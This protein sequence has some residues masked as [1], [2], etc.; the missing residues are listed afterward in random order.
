MQNRMSNMELLRILAMFFIVISHVAHH[1]GLP[2]FDI[3]H[4]LTFNYIISQMFILLGRIGTV[5]FVMLTGFFAVKSGFKISSLSKLWLL[6]F[7]YSNVLFF[8]FVFSGS[9]IINIRNII[10]TI[11]PISFNQYWFVSCYFFLYLL[12][13]LIN[14]CINNLNKK[15]HFAVCLIW[16]L[17]W[18]VI[19]SFILYPGYVTGVHWSILGW[20]VA[21]YFIGSYIRLYVD[22]SYVAKKVNKIRL[23]VLLSFGLMFLYLMCLNL[24]ARSEIHLDMWN[25][26]DRNNIFVIISAVLLFLIFVGKS[27]KSIIWINRISV[28]MIGVYMVHCNRLTLPWLMQHVF[29][30]SKYFESPYFVLRVLYVSILVF[31]GSLAVEYIRRL[32]FRKCS[33]NFTACM[34]RHDIAIQ[35]FF[36]QQ[37]FI[38]K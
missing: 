1:S 18:S 35:E 8:I 16:L 21:L 13:P 24:L 26:L 34:K 30:T 14:I 19:P 17:V 12:S 33:E 2:V 7:F 6:T 20:F 4:E 11:L 38:K 28:C 10:E 3:S 36:K 22:S 25:Y 32:M 37:Q 9:E 29:N 31:I 23:S 5:L 15:Q 27:S